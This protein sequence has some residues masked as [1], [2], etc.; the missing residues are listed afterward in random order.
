LL[1]LQVTKLVENSPEDLNKLLEFYSPNPV[2]L[3]PMPSQTEKGK[4]KQGSD[5]SAPQGKGIKKEPAAFGQA[6]EKDRVYTQSTHLSFRGGTDQ[7]KRAN[8]DHK[9]RAT[10]RLCCCAYPSFVHF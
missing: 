3:L 8:F 1:G 6:E 10:R 7:K 4:K 9:W 5:K 2:E